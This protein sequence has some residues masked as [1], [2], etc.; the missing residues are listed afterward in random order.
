[1]I[2]TCEICGCEFVAQRS[3]AKYCSAT[4][5]KRKERGYAFIGELETPDYRASLPDEDVAA[6]IQQAHNVAADLSRAAMLTPSPL[7]LSLG[8]VSRKIEECLRGEG[9]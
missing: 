9:L 4:C 3:T 7:C 1:M 6:I 5:R 8:R 2:K